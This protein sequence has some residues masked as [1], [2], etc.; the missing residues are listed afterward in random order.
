MVVLMKKLVLG[1]MFNNLDID[2]IF[3]HLAHFYQVGDWSEVLWIHLTVFLVEW[4]YELWF[5]LG[6]KPLFSS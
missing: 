4:E 1:E 6:S 2:S 3:N 5:P